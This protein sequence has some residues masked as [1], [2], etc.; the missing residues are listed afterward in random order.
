MTLLASTSRISLEDDS[1]PYNQFWYSLSNPLTRKYYERRINKFF[2]TVE[3][4]SGLDFQNRF[5]SFA[6]RGMEDNDWAA[7]IATR[8][9]RYEVESPAW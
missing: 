9:L 8:F 2:D 6:K 7:R 1:S 5:D 3:F 4:G